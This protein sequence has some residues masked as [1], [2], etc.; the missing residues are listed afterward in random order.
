MSDNVYW[1]FEVA[2][3]PGKNDAFKALAK[4]MI[5]ET[6]TQRP[7]VLGYHWNLSEDGNTC[8]IYERFKTCDAAMVH[9]NNFGKNWAAKFLDVVTPGKLNVYGKAND[10]VRNALAPFA[11]TYRNHFDGFIR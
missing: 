11:P 5:A 9:I 6:K 8:A 1:I 4:E 2:V 3:K 7:D 10:E